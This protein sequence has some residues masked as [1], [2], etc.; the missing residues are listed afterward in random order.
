VTIAPGER[1]ALPPRN[2]EERSYYPG[3]TDYGDSTTL[4][5]HWL[6]PEST[7]RVSFTFANRQAELGGKAVWTGAA[8]SGAATV[9]VTASLEGLKIKAGFELAQTE[10][11]LGEPIWVTFR[12]TNEGDKPFA[13][14]VGGDYRFTGRHERFSISAVDELGEKVP[15]PIPDPSRGDGISW[16][17]KVELGKPYTEELLVNRR[18][19]FSKPGRY[20]LTC[21]RTLNIN[22]DSDAG[23]ARV[24]EAVLP[25]LPVETTSTITLR[26]DDKAFGEYLDALVK[27]L[28]GPYDG[29]AYGEMTQVAKA[30]TPAALPAIIRLA[31]VADPNQQQRVSW[32][33][34]YGEEANAALLE[35]AETGIPSARATALGALS[36][37]GVPGLE[38][39]VLKALKS[40]NA[41]ERQGAVQI[42]E[43][44]R[45]PGC[46]ETLLGM[47]EDPD[48]WVREFLCRALGAYGDQRGAPILRKILLAPDATPY[49]RTCAATALHGLGH[50][51]GIAALIDLL[52]AEEMRN[53]WAWYGS[54]LMTLTGQQLPATYEAW[55]KWWAEQG[56]K[57]G[58]PGQP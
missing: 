56:S 44:G 42:C 15:D 47:G 8:T 4:R 5:R 51:D 48:K 36:R 19:A 3:Q 25:T 34:S 20:T 46:L 31:K 18:C 41:Q 32:L 16:E 54:T 38:P 12:V 53:D 17:P 26:A 37:R 10:F 33:C 50:D 43:R 52:K 24:P 2:L 30:K 58:A 14:V 40:E 55:H 21:R 57:P 28:E 13:F 39:L 7:Y 45:Y 29:K 35:V 27:R 11:A 22:K 49:A 9:K 6:L 23:M 1:L